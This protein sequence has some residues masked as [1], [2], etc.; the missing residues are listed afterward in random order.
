MLSSG[1]LSLFMYEEQRF[2]NNSWKHKI[3][4]WSYK[5]R[6]KLHQLQVLIVCTNICRFNTQLNNQFPET[7]AIFID[8]NKDNYVLERRKSLFQTFL[9]NIAISLAQNCYF[10]VNNGSTRTICEKTP[11]RHQD[12]S[13]DVVLVSLLLTLLRFHTLLLCFYY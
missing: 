2:L 10:K 8:F 5:I 11:Q 3:L 9:K 13:T 12:N 7:D 4:N 1:L 6:K